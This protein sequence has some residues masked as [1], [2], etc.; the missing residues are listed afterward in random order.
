M[1]FFCSYVR[2]VPCPLIVVSN[3]YAHG[4]ED[5]SS[6]VAHSDSYINNVAVNNLPRT[7]FWPKVRS[8]TI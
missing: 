2:T 3:E 8:R 6:Q 5:S 4:E 7:S 1:S